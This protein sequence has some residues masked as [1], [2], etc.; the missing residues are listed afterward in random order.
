MKIESRLLTVCVCV[1][2][3]VALVVV[4]QDGAKKEVDGTV[5]KLGD[6]SE[7]SI[8]QGED[9]VLTLVQKDSEEAMKALIVIRSI[10]SKTVEIYAE[11]TKTDVMVEI[12]DGEIVRNTWIYQK[13][14]KKVFCR[15]TNGDGFPDIKVEIDQL[16]RDVVSYEIDYNE[17]QLAE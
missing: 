5:F 7:V 10:S 12:A 1:L 9:G 8:K 3:M 14:D 15:D 17:K 16:L 4:G 2:C 13:G 6:G 11:K